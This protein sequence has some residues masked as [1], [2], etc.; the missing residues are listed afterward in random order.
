MPKRQSADISPSA[1]TRSRSTIANKPATSFALVLCGRSQPLSAHCF[2]LI[3]GSNHKQPRLAEHRC[4]EML[5]SLPSLHKF[6]RTQNVRVHF[7][8]E[9]RSDAR[10]PLAELPQTDCTY[11][12][13]VHI[14]PRLT[15]AS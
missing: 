4:N 3:F 14:A 6:L 7:A 5:A 15:V 1:S 10:Q 11:H 2:K 12:H 13:Q 8:A 9:F